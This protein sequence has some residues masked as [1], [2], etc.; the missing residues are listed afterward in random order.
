VRPQIS[1]QRSGMRRVDWPR[2]EFHFARNPAGPHDI[3]IG[4]GVE[5]NLAWREFGGCCIELCRQV[6]AS[7]VVSLGA[8]L[9]DVPH[10]RAT[11]VTGTAL[12]PNVAVRLDLTT[13]RYEGPTGI[14]GVIHD[15][16]RRESVPAASL[17]ANV[18]HYITTSQ[19]P[20]ATRALLTRLQELLGLR[21]DLRELEAAGERFVAEVDTALS[22]NPQVAEYVRTLEAAADEAPAAPEEPLPS[23]EDAISDIEEFLRQQRDE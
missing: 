4:I 10:T 7:L 12:D 21:F 13:S 3:V 11:R 6:G 22:A 16:L 5:P 19:N 18:P 15:A 20:P 17:W 1:I 2:N 14:V 23:G 8:L 9:A